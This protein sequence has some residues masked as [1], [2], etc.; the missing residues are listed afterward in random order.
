MSFIE[1]EKS[2]MSSN[3]F[4]TLLYQKAHKSSV[5]SHTQFT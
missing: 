2:L 4:S 3:E 5:I 1:P